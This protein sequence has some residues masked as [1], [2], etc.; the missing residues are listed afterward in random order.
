MSVD[1]LPWPTGMLPV[2]TMIGRP[3]MPCPI[4]AVDTG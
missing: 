4:K 2:I 1:R 3:A